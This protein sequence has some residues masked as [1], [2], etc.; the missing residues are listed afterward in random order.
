MLIEIFFQV[1]CVPQSGTCCRLTKSFNL[2]VRNRSQNFSGGV[3]LS[4]YHLSDTSYDAINTSAF[5]K[6]NK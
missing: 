4:S 2:D 3:F 5:L 6:E 1:Q